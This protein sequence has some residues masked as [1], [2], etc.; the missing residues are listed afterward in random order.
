[1]AGKTKA[2]YKGDGGPA[3]NALL[4]FPS[5]VAVDAAGNLF[6]AEARERV[7]RVDAAT[8]VITTVAGAGRKGDKR[9]DVP[10]T[11]ARV[12]PHA[13]AV[14]AAGNLFVGEYYGRLRRVDATT[15]IISAVAGGQIYFPPLGDGGRATSASVFPAG[16]TADPAGNL[17]ISGDQRLRRVDSAT[18]T[19]TTIAG[20]GRVWIPA[21]NNVP[22]TQVAFHTNGVTSDAGGNIFVADFWHHRVWRLDA[23]TGIVTTVA[24]TGNSYPDGGYDGD[25]GPATEARLNQPRDVALDSTGKLYIAEGV[26][27]L[28]TAYMMRIRR[29]DLTTGIIT[30]FAGTGEWG[31]NG[32]GIPATEANLSYPYGGIAVDAAGNL[33]ITDLPSRIRRVDAKTGI[34]TTVAGNGLCVCEAGPTGD[35]G[36][37]LE[38]QFLNPADIAIDPA[39]NLFISDSGDNRIR[40]VDAVTGII[41]TV[42][43]TGEGGFYGD[44]GP[45]TAANIYSPG[46]LALDGAGNLYIGDLANSRVCVVK[47]IAAPAGHSSAAKLGVAVY[48]APERTTMRGASERS[49]SPV[50]DYRRPADRLSW[51]RTRYEKRRFRKTQL[52]CSGAD[53][54][55]GDFARARTDSP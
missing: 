17:V 53:I 51:E 47:G 23:V 5:D 12:D 50:G 54:D 48:R 19:I 39:G 40:R 52:P 2:G 4:S 10:A 36:P 41:T 21:Q 33:Y 29:V 7:R 26:A 11:T 18:G 27:Q 30:T 44:G 24:G 20:G 28:P 49:G 45:A 43:G 46:A 31:Y 14:D 1:V 9:D 35:G 25:G 22:G 16:V 13:L 42:V 32:D 38:A 15:G 55:T 8:G 6:I 3:T 34:I 37:A